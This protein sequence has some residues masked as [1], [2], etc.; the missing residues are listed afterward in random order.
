LR[1]ISPSLYREFIKP[2]HAELFDL[3]KERRLN[4]SLHICGYVDPI[5]KDL[6]DLP[7]AAYSIDAPTSM[8]LFRELAGTK[9]VVIGNVATPLFAEGTPRRSRQPRRK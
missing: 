7:V 1:L 8:K 3:F 2:Y 6:L 4:V 9:T 5:L